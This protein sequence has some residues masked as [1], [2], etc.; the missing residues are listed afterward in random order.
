PAVDLRRFV[1]DLDGK[2][3]PRACGG[4][5]AVDEQVGIKC[6]ARASGA[7]GHTGAGHS[8]TVRRDR[9]GRLRSATPFASAQ[10][11]GRVLLPAQGS[12][13]AYGVPVRAGRPAGPGG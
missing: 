10:A 2:L 8:R 7:W 3:V 4:I 13:R 12:A 9:A 1:N 11:H 6:E 5:D